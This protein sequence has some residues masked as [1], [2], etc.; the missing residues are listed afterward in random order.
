[1]FK[2]LYDLSG[3]RLYSIGR[4][5]DNNIVLTYSDPKVSENHAII[6]TKLPEIVDLGSFNGTYVNKKS[7][8]R[9]YVNNHNEFS[10]DIKT[11]VEI[12]KQ[13]LEKL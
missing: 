13:F 2:D 8:G 11:F 3:S 1:M 5:G 9:L 7:V 4:G 6:D 12:I 10:E